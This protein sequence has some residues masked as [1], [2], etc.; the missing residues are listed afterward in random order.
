[1]TLNCRSPWSLEVNAAVLFSIFGMDLH[2]ASIR[3]LKSKVE[4][5]FATGKGI[6]G[7]IYPWKRVAVLLGDVVKFSIVARKIL[8]S[9]LSSCEPRRLEMPRISKMD[10]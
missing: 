10:L 2:S 1:M 9:H 4:E 3:A 6:Q 7:A 5:P 8:W